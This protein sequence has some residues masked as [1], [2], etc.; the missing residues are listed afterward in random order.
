[1]NRALSGMLKSASREFDNIQFKIIDIDKQTDSSVVLDEVLHGED[2]VLSAYRR[3]SRFIEAF[4]ELV[5]SE[6]REISIKND[7]VYIIT[8]A[9]AVLV[10]LLQS[11]WL[12]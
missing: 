12:K 1:M 2:M 7:G 9:L 4:S 10:L 3:N 5:Q 6:R 8:G 11:S